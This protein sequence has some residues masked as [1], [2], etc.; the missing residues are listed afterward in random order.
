MVI[1]IKATSM[2]K[3]KYLLDDIDFL[4]FEHKNTQ[5]QIIFQQNC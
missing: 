1:H 2:N 4:Q 3:K 5:M